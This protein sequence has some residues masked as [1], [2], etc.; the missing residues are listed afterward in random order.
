[1][2]MHCKKTPARILRHGYNDYLILKLQL[3]KTLSLLAFKPMFGDL[4]VL[5]FYFN[6]NFN[7]KYLDTCFARP[8]YFYPGFEL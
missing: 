3:E 5:S 6:F 1:M 4:T 2:D 8:Y 7:N